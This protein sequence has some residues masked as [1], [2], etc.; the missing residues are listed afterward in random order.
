MPYSLGSG[1]THEAFSNRTNTSDPLANRHL[2]RTPHLLCVDDNPANLLLV[3]TLLT[4]MGAQVK[5]VS[6]FLP[7]HVL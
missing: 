1:P 5:G 6:N 2:E 3:K 4:D 7:H